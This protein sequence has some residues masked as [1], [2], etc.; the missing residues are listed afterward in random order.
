MYITISI[1]AFFSDRST[2]IKKFESQ[3]AIYLPT[4]IFIYFLYCGKGNA[5]FYFG[6]WQG[7]LYA[8]RR[9]K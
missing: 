5:K 9:N 1:M 4:V 6:R 2:S 7:K 3:E 8:P